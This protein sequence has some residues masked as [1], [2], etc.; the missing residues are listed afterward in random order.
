MAE[1][2][3]SFTSIT[4]IGLVVCFVLPILMNVTAFYIPLIDFNIGYAQF[5]GNWIHIYFPISVFICVAFYAA[6]EPREN[7]IHFV[8]VLVSA[9]WGVILV[10]LNLLGYHS[11]FIFP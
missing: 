1:K 4:I 2:N 3:A 8:C 7:R 5:I 6:L 9:G 11:G 10:A